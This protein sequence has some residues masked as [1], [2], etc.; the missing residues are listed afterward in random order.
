MNFTQEQ[1]AEVAE[2]ILLGALDRIE[3]NL[4]DTIPLAVYHEKVVAID[5][6]M[7]AAMD[8]AAMALAILFAQTTGEGMG[9]WDWAG[10][11]E[12]SDLCDKLVDER[13]D[14]RWPGLKP[15]NR[16]LPDVTEV[17]QLFADEW[18]QTFEPEIPV[19]F[20]TF[21]NGGEVFALF[22][23]L[24][25]DATGKLC[26]GYTDAGHDGADYNKCIKASRPAKPHEFANL[27]AELEQANYRLRIVPRATAQMHIQRRNEARS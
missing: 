17:A 15:G 4:P 8:T 9:V 25:S 7:A 19:L 11:T 23:T 16:I 3:S 18:A 14:P 27:K 12:F 6:A 24:P 1:I 2:Y 21:R 13:T 22:P 5:R 10:A 26:L 20:R